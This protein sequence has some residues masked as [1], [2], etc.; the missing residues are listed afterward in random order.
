MSIL[1]HPW[2]CRMSPHGTVYHWSSNL[3]IESWS[4]SF[5]FLVFLR[6]LGCDAWST[7][8]ILT[9]H[10]ST[11]FCLI[12]WRNILLRSNLLRT[13][14]RLIFNGLIPICIAHLVF[15]RILECLMMHLSC[16]IWDKIYFV[17][18]TLLRFLLRNC[19]GS[20]FYFVGCRL[21]CWYR[22]RSD[23]HYLWVL[24]INLPYLNPRLHL[25]IARESPMI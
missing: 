3:T 9:L 18:E 4:T 11:F 17:E 10:Y 6:P 19:R 2:S 20:T 8:C 23:F 14:N 5:G 13:V 12:H 1:G 15:N 25:N 7:L 24:E 21:R 22:F 16:L